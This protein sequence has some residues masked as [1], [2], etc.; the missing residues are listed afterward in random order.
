ML[1]PVNSSPYFDVRSCM[2]KTDARAL[3]ESIMTKREILLVMIGLMSGMF[4]S[5]LDQTVVSTSMRTIADDL[6]G[7]S[8]QAWVTTAYMIM[9]TI[10]TPLYGKLSDIFGRRPLF[11]IAISVFVLGSLLAGTADTMYQLA[12]YRAIQGLGAGGLMALP[13]A[14]MGDMLAPRERA[15]YQG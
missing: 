15:K 2:S 1:F 10:S 13:L 4:L 14:I 9:S 5:A 11:I 8:L 12:G 3:G 7:M 6:D